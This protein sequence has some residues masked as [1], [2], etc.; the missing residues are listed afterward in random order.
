MAAEIIYNSDLLERLEVADSHDFRDDLDHAAEEREHVRI[1][2]VELSLQAI[3]EIAR[4]V[5]HIRDLQELEDAEI[6][7]N[8]KNLPLRKSVKALSRICCDPR[9]I[10]ALM[11]HASDHPDWAWINF[12]TV[13][14][15]EMTRKEMA[16]MRKL[17]PSTVKYLIDKVELPEDA[18]EFVPENRI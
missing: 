10:V 17:N 14:C 5:Q 12:W 18:Y 1:Q 15:P 6:R 13:F 3:L 7:I 9:R 11:L 8:G 2:P 16:A 4:A